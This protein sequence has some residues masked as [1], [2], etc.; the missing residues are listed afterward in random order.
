MVELKVEKMAVADLIPYS[1]NAKAHT[2]KQVKQIAASIKEFGF[3]DPI[4]ID[5]KGNEII[6]GHGRFEA[7]KLLKLKNVP[8]IKLGH[9]SEVQ[10]RAY[11]IA[12]NKITSNTGFNN[13]ALTIEFDFLK[14]EDFNLELTGFDLDDWQLG[15]IPFD[16]GDLPQELPPPKITGEDTRQGRY[17]LV[18]TNEIE[19]KAIADRIGVGGDKVVY[20][21]NDMN[22]D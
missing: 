14:E 17:I 10:K 12:H 11:R 16:D 13:D 15:D 9:L 20:M 7:A 22:F 18:Y 8:I 2:I 4:A 5:E 1:N 3:N 19:R 6:A 21:F